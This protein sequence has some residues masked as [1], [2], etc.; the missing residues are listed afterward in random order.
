MGTITINV[1]D[2]IEQEFRETVKKEIGEGKGKLGSA[3]E[4]AIKGWVKEKRQKEIVDSLKE[5]MQK[6]LYSVGKG[7][8]FNRAEIYDRGKQR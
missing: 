5:K 2:E 1:S 3:V 4:E 7:W 8:K 6:G